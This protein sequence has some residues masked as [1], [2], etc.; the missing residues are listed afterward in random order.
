MEK[1]PEI[2]MLLDED[3]PDPFQYI[4]DDDIDFTGWDDVSGYNENWE[5]EE[6]ERRDSLIAEWRKTL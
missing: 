6:K 1:D 2:D 5:K 3:G 4:T